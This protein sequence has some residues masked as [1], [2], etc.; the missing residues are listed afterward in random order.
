[1]SSMDLYDDLFLD[2]E[3]SKVGTSNHDIHGLTCEEKRL[4]DENQKLQEELNT[5]KREN[6]NWQ[7]VYCDVVQKLENSKY[8]ISTLLK[9][10]QNELKRKNE[11]ISGLKK[12]LD[13]IL[14]KRALKSGTTNE[15]KNM[16]DKIHQAFKFEINGCVQER[17]TSSEEEKEVKH[18]RCQKESNTVNTNASSGKYAL[19]QLISGTE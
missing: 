17:A 4:K 9:T 12:E 8:N 14:F 16:I 5:L 3:S 10:T 19:R 6:E 13:N 1:M 18:I 11:T 2:S 15:L 7:L